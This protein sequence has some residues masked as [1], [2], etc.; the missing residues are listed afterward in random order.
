MFKIKFQNFRLFAEQI[1]IVWPVANFD[2]GE[3]FE[4]DIYANGIRLGT[5]TN[6]ILNLRNMLQSAYVLEK[7]WRDEVTE[8]QRQRCTVMPEPTLSQAQLILMIASRC[9]SIGEPLGKKT[10]K[11]WNKVMVN[12]LGDWVAVPHEDGELIKVKG[13]YVVGEFR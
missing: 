5:T 9:P 4:Y 13:N 2:T 12:R 7:K 8:L 10:D 6:R 11:C 1:E 3:P